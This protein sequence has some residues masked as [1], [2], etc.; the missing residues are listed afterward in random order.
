M[1]SFLATLT[2]YLVLNSPIN[3][4][5]LS[6]APSYLLLDTTL[7]AL[8][9]THISKT[10]RS[11]TIYSGEKVVISLKN[12][13]RPFRGKLSFLSKDTILLQGKKSVKASLNQIVKLRRERTPWRKELKIF[14]SSLAI[15]AGVLIAYVGLISVSLF[16]FDPTGVTYLSLLGGLLLV[17]TPFL[18]SFKYRPKRLRVKYNATIVELDNE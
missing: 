8:I 15:L 1:K 5:G 16:G 13:Q 18:N 9:L 6:H 17:L 4:F 11:D 3:A 14:L 7:N 12:P 10:K 2:L